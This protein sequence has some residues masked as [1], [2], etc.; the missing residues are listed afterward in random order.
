MLK[1]DPITVIQWAIGGLL[2]LLATWVALLNWM[3]FVKGEILRR[4]TG[5]WVPLFAGVTAC[6][7]L[8]VVP[9]EGLARYWFIPFLVDWGSVPGIA[10]TVVRM[11]S[12]AK[13]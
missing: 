12:D 3:I 10:V 9:V 4:P 13:R 6:L 11:R 8:L 7:G 1:P 2:I 5:S